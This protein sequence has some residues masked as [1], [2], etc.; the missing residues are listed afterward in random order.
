MINTVRKSIFIIMIMRASYIK[1]KS[2]LQ[3]QLLS[4][5]HHNDNHNL[6][7]IKQYHP[8]ADS[9]STLLHLLARSDS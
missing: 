1:D 2:I 8:L 5:Y 6:L 3:L 4:Y 9:T 7:F